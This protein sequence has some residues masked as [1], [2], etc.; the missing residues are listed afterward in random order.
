VTLAWTLPETSEGYRAI[1]VMRNTT[2]SAQGRGRIRTVRATVT[3]IEDTVP[4]TAAPYWYWLKLTTTSN[5]VTNLG[6]FEAV[7]AK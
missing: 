3:G 4:D 1:E 5:T 2:S 7:E 6:P